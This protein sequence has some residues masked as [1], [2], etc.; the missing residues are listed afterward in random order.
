ME[1]WNPNLY[2][3]FCDERTQP[4]IDLVNRIQLDN[5]ENIIDIGCGPGN[6][7]EIL[8]NRWPNAH[9]TG[10]DASE[11]MLAKAKENLPSLSWISGDASTFQSEQKYDLV[12]SNAVIQWIPDHKALLKSFYNLLKPGGT[13]AIQIPLF[14]DMPLGHVIAEVG[15][16]ERWGDR[17]LALDGHLTTHNC[18]EYYNIMADIF[19]KVDFWRTDYYHVLDNHM[20]MLDMMRSTG[21]KLYYQ[22]LEQEERYDFEQEVLWG[23]E[24]AYPHQPNGKVILP[25][26]R[27]FLLCEKG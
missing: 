11:S 16:D 1:D 8:V 9:I 18:S 10:L 6:A 3:Q 22:V 24:K 15:L 27:I 21:F 25:F 7:T 26:K 4:A 13:L 14:E 12:F 2:L 17:T 19:E 20:T 5:P 23:I